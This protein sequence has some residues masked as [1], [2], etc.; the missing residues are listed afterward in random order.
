MAEPTPGP[1]ICRQGIISTTDHRIVGYTSTH[2]ASYAIDSEAELDANGRA[3]A[4]VPVLIAALRIISNMNAT[5]PLSLGD[6]VY[7]V[8][9]A[10]HALTVAL[11]G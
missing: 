4:A 7:A 5:E 3:M 2:S 6:Q 9:S 1:W 10:R 8:T 11:G